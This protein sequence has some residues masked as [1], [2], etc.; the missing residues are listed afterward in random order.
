MIKNNNNNNK[1]VKRK[2]ETLDEP[3][4]TNIKNE[5]SK[6]TKKIKTTTTT[7]TTKSD[8]PVRG[9]KFKKPQKQQLIEKVKVELENN[10]QVYI[11]PVITTA[12]VVEATAISSNWN[13]AKSQIKEQ[14]SSFYQKKKTHDNSN[15]VSSTAEEQTKSKK[16]LGPE[17]KELSKLF[18]SNSK[19]K[20]ISKILSMDCKIV[21]VSGHKAAL[22]KICIVN[23]SFN[24]IYEKIIKPEDTIIDYR[25][26]FTGL[27]KEIV[28]KQG[29]DFLVA[30]KEILK[31]IKDKILVG[32]DLS[33]D[34]KVLKLAHKKQLLRDLMTFPAH[35]NNDKSPQSL[36]AIARLELNFSPDKWDFNDSIRDCI[37]TQ[38]IHNIHKKEWEQYITSKYYSGS[39]PKKINNNEKNIDNN[40]ED[41]NDNDNYEN[42]DISDINE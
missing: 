18:E 1:Q 28:D 15:V 13:A 31:I 27:T 36:K 21:E 39:K 16:P 26:K 42:E 4:V 38:L 14:K 22:G 41:D 10:K 2:S 12:N 11:A 30:Q 19:D 33:E 23:R 6:P 29:V 40:D 3:I 7:K 35:L 24:V 8:K 9:I 20:T 25:T 34:F 32:H 37:L 5:K 17:I